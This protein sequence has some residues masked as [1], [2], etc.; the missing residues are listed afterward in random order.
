MILEC[1][2][3]D[4]DETEDFNPDCNNSNFKE[5]QKGQ[6]RKRDEEYDEDED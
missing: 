3:K 4:E 5:N 1:L 6:K 2:F